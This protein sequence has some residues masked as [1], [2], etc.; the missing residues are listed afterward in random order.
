MVLLTTEQ[1]ILFFQGRRQFG[2]RKI[3]KD[4]GRPYSD[5]LLE[6]PYSGFYRIRRINGKQYH[7]VLPFY[8]PSN[9]Q[10]LAQQAWRYIFRDAI[11][12]WRLLSPEQKA[13]WKQKGARRMIP[14]YNAFISAYL[15][16]HKTQ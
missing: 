5:A 3:D 11:D 1:R 12:A 16:I 8:K 14:A 10:T 2:W 7:E 4:Q 6:N 15:L 13:V 9:P